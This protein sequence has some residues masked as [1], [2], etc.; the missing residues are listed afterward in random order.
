MNRR[1]R[2]LLAWAAAALLGLSA[3]LLLWPAASTPPAPAPSA[4]PSLLPSPA[5]A[6]PPAA[7]LG[8]ARR[9]YAVGLHELRGLPPSAPPGLRL[10]LWVA[11]EPPVVDRPRVSLLLRDVILE[12]IIPPATPE[13]PSAAV[14][15]VRR[16]DLVDLLYADRWGNLAV[17]VTGS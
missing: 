15:S 2:V 5:P 6:A 8:P 12:Q 3:V 10:E 11:W 9:S 17:A 13:G 16:R 1:T 14:L 7:A 4:P